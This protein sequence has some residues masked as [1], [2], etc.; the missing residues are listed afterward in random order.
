MSISPNKKMTQRTLNALETRNTLFKTAIKLFS[1]YGYDKVKVED[2]TNAAAVSK[3]TFYHHF[4]TKEAIL[5][6]Q[7]DKIDQ[8][9]DEIF[10]SVPK[11]T[12]AGEQLLLLVQAMTQY[13]AEICGIQ[14][15]RIVYCSQINQISTTH[16]LNNKN[17]RIYHY[18]QR[19]VTIGKSTGEF[20]CTLPEEEL[21]EYLMRA[22]RSLIYDWCLSGGDYSLLQYGKT[23]LPM[24]FGGFRTA[25]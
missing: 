1:E 25:S 12:P 15:M 14:V 22:C 23:M 8:Y 7:F 6:E 19:I 17:R 21:V 10:A 9:Y 16:I 13:C 5:V 4:E 18:L 20:T 2:I 24:F 3:G 11:D